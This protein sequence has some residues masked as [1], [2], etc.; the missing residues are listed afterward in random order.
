MP[1]LT[2]TISGATNGDRIADA[3]TDRDT[4]SSAPIGGADYQARTG[5]IDEEPITER[6]A[7]IIGD[8][9]GIRLTRNG[10]PD[11]RSTRG[12]RG[13]GATGNA[14]EKTTVSLGSFSIGDLLLGIHAMLASATHTPELELDAKSGEHDKLGKAITDVAAQYGHQVNPKVAA[15]MNLMIVSGAI[16]GTRY[17]AISMRMKM[18]R[19]MQRLKVT[20]INDH[21]ANGAPK[22][23]VQPLTPDFESGGL[24]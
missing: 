9:T 24:N 15:W 19:D 10:R 18:G 7:D 16:Y 3:G 2:D 5:Y 13:R 17:A 14:D 21:A 11:G 23:P 12:R 1:E 8:T 22:P 20:A 4:I 6:V